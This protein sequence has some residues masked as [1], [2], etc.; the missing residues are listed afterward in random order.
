MSIYLFRDKKKKRFEF[1][2][3]FNVTINYGKNNFA[4]STH[5]YIFNI[6]YDFYMIK[7]S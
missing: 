5:I 3:F 1:T 7:L 4:N 2:I 6:K